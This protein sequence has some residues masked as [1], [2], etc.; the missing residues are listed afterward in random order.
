MTEIMNSDIKSCVV[1]LYWI[2]SA[3]CA[4]SIFSLSARS[5]IVLDSFNIRW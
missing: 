1:A 5:A 3:K 4:G 2:A